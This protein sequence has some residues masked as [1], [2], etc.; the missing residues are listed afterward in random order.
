MTPEQRIDHCIDF[1]N[2]NM[3][4][5]GEFFKKAY[6]IHRQRNVRMWLHIVGT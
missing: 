3:R 1:L 4:K 6:D 2:E 5:W